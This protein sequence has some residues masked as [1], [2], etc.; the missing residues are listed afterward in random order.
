MTIPEAASLVLIAGTYAEGGE[1]FVLDM[2]DPVKIDDLAR[3][4]IRLSGLKHDKDIRIEYTGLRPG[5]KL[6]EERLMSEEGLLTT[7]NELIHI[8]KPI[9][10]DE[11]R[12]LKG[13][14]V[15]MTVAYENTEA[16]RLLI[17]GLVETYK[18]SAPLSMEEKARYDRE[19]SRIV[20]RW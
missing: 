14:N 13:L 10:F 6:Y 18:P 8:G 15:V 3:N 5:E 17:E 1:I 4:L 12:F 9:A 20:R 11:D 7:P 19:I 16:V 2:G